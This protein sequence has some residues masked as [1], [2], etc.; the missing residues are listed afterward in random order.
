MIL[1]MSPDEQ[2]FLPINVYIVSWQLKI[3]IK[4]NSVAIIKFCSFP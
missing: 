4:D 1:L 3:Q 2:T